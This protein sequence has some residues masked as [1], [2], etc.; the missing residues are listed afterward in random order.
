MQTQQIFWADWNLLSKTGETFTVFSDREP[1]PVEEG[2]VLKP[3][4]VTSGYGG[5]E[6][7]DVSHLFLLRVKEVRQVP[8]LFV[9]SVWKVTM[10]KEAKDGA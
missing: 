8:E 9:G 7:I 10:V 5:G 4:Y 2:E 6:E 3:L 1:C